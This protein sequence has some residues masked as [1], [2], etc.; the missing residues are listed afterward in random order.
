MVIRVRIHDSVL[1]LVW[2]LFY[3]MQIEENHKIFFFSFVIHGIVRGMLFS[4]R[5]TTFMF[6]GVISHHPFRASLS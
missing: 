2:L 3:P 4:G 6:L 5:N 1:L